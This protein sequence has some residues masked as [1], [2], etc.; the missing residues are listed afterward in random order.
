MKIIEAVFVAL[1]IVWL[2][3]IMWVV[4]TIPTPTQ[5]MDRWV[6]GGGMLLLGLLGVLAL[7]CLLES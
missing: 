2:L 1:F 7:V 3:G 6:Y 4:W 5:E